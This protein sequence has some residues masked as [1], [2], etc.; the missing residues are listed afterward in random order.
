M[1]LIIYLKETKRKSKGP[2]SHTYTGNKRNSINDLE[3][4]QHTTADEE[5]LLQ[6]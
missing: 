5:G 6:K 2:K 1:K 4:K 3:V